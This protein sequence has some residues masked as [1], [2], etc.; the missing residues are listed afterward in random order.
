MTLLAAALISLVLAFFVVQGVLM[1]V[2]P[3][4][5]FAFLKWYTSIGG[6]KTQKV[7]PGPHTQMRIAGLIIILLSMVCAYGLAE[8]ILKML[9]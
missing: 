4:R 3:G 1:C 7:P 6:R 5:Y 8:R 2:S 9:G